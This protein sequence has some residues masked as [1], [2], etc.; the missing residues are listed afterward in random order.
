MTTGDGTGTPEDDRPFA[1]LGAIGSAWRG[2]AVGRRRAIRHLVLLV[3]AIGLVLGFWY[4]A[5]LYTCGLPLLVIGGALGT[6]VVLKL[7]A[8]TLGPEEE[9]ARTPGVQVVAEGGR[10]R[11]VRC[12]S[13]GG[14]LRVTAPTHGG[15]EGPVEISCPH[16]GRS[17]K[18]PL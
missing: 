11:R 4:H 10:Q 16:C 6:F 14:M 9:G 12:A 3:V 15:P 17:G 2:L 18:V 13:C 7:L 1:S 8:W 5:V